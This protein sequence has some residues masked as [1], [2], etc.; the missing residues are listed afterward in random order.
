MTFQTTRYT[1]VRGDYSNQYPAIT[2]LFH[3][4]GGFLYYKW[5]ICNPVD[6]FDREIGYEMA[7][8][9]QGMMT[10]YNSEEPLVTSAIES[11]QNSLEFANTMP[12]SNVNQLNKQRVKKCLSTFDYIMSVNVGEEIVL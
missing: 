2:W 7:E 11:L 10:N 3:V 5:S 1:K 9:Q 8:R 4:N 6:N 12:K